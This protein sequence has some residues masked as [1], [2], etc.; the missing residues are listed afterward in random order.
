MVART[1]KIGE[2]V[3]VDIDNSYIGQGE[4]VSIDGKKKDFHFSGDEMNV[5]VEVRIKVLNLNIL[6]DD[7]SEMTL[8]GVYHFENQF[9]YQIA[10]GKTF[11]SEFV[12]YENDDEDEYEYF[13]PIQGIVL[14][15]DDL[16]GAN[17]RY[18]SGYDY[19]QKQ[20]ESGRWDLDS[21]TFDVKQALADA[22][23]EGF[24]Q[25]QES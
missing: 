20:I 6:V 22:F 12:C 14:N 9:I 25:G 10:E 13:A 23:D 1:L 19:V 8:E 4:I 5:D 18:C 16:D 11:E 2:I 24:A 7:D 3:C 21:D 17:E 15:E